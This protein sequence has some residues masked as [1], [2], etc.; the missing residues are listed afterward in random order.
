MIAFMSLCDM[1]DDKYMPCEIAVAEFSLRRGIQRLFHKFIKPGNFVVIKEKF[2]VL[3]QGNFL[4]DDLII[5]QLC[6]VTC[7]IT[8]GIE[9][10]M[11]VKH[12]F[13]ARNLVGDYPSRRWTHSTSADEGKKSQLA[14]VRIIVERPKN[15]KIKNVSSS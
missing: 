4:L 3:L 2:Y 6:I 1:P 11:N 7:W 15:F 9:L 10:N 14:T 8:F 12:R 5:Y 13:V